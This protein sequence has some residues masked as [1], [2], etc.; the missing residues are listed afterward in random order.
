MLAGVVHVIVDA[1]HDRQVFALGGRADD[2][3][4]RAAAVDMCPRLVGAREASR[5]LDYKLDAQ[6]VPGDRGG[7]ALRNHFDPLAVDAD[8]A[9]DGADLAGEGAVGAVVFQ[10]MGVGLWIGEVVYGNDFDVIRMV[11][12]D[13]LEDLAADAAEP[14][15]A[16]SG[17]HG[18]SLLCSQDASSVYEVWMEVSGVRCQLLGVPEA[19]RVSGGGTH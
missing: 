3:L 11:V 18:V 16:D 14:V 2:D 9:V 13:S 8:G 17:G 12:V 5:G 15:D 4:L 10:K 6:F 19:G 7:V 1:E